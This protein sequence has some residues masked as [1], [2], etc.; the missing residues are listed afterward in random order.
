[1]LEELKE[2]MEKFGYQFNERSLGGKWFCGYPDTNP[3]S[4]SQNLT[5]SQCFAGLCYG[6]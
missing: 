6:K 3:M 2:Q 5:F 4:T 1:M